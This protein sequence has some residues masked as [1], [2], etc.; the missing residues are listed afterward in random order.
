MLHNLGLE[1]T[2]V[3]QFVAELRDVKVQADSMRFRRNLER[4]GQICAFEISKT[5]A[6]KQIEVETPLG[7]AEVN[8]PDERIVIGSVLRAG[9]PLHDGVLSVFDTAENA[10]FAAFRASHKGGE[11]E[12]ALKYM[13]CPRLDGAVFILA[14]AMLATGSTAHKVFEAVKDFGKPKAFHLVTAIAAMD[15]INHIKRYYSRA[16]VWAAAVDKELTAKAYIVPGL[17][18]AGDLA[19]GEKIQVD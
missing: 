13:T 4:I 1:N 17:G 19:F 2:V 15:G 12:I 8:V 14:D 6:Y 10:F 18:D 3:N 9:L 5:L 16:H 11:F 7:I